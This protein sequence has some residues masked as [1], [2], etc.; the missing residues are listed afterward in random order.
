MC[1]MCWIE[2]ISVGLSDTIVGVHV[3]N[4]DFILGLAAPA[5]EAL[6]TQISSEVNCLAWE[7]KLI[8]NFMDK[9]K[10]KSKILTTD[11]LL[12][13]CMLAKLQISVDKTLCH[14]GKPGLHSDPNLATFL[15]TANALVPCLAQII[16]KLND[17]ARTQV[18]NIFSNQLMDYKYYV[19]YFYG[20]LY[21][22]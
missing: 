3:C 9:L 6:I 5:A 16:E 2:C 1:C 22:K 14:A 17:V 12:V 4:S 21:L 18:S 15:Q 7:V 8:S 11:L 19:Y 10:T 20:T 13:D